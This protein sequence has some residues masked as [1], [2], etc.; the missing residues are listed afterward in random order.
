MNQIMKCPICGDDMH[1]YKEIKAGIN[2]Q[3]YCCKK[4][5]IGFFA[6]KNHDDFFTYLDSNLMK[7]SSKQEQIDWLEK[8]LEQQAECF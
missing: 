4:C 8:K 3:G 2:E 1:L 5:E 7:R 6:Y